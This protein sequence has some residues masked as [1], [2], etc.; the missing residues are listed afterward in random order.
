MVLA[1][2]AGFGQEPEDK[3]LRQVL[4][5]FEDLDYPTIA[6]AVNQQGIVVVDVKLDDEGTPMTASALTGPELLVSA[7]TTNATKW[8][9]KPNAQR[10]AIIVYDFSIDSGACHDRSRSLFLLKHPNFAK[11]ESCMN[12]I[13]G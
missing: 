4:I 3:P 10:R 11:I 2:V 8:R 6:R 7:A 5:S 1:V 12:V 9:F 13:E